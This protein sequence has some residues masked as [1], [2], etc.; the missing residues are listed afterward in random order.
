MPHHVSE[1]EYSAPPPV[2]DSPAV[3]RVLTPEPCRCRTRRR[4]RCRRTGISATTN[5]GIARL[6]ERADTFAWHRVSRGGLNPSIYSAD[7][8]WDMAACNLSGRLLGLRLYAPAD[9]RHAL[10]PTVGITDLVKRR[11]P[12]RANSPRRVPHGRQGC[13]AGGVSAIGGDLLRASPATARR[14]PQRPRLAAEFSRTARLLIPSRRAQSAP[15]SRRSGT[16]RS[17]A[18]PPRRLAWNGWRPM[19]VL[20]VGPRWVFVSALVRRL[21][22]GARC[23][24]RVGAGVLVL[25]G[26]RPCSQRVLHRRFVHR[27]GYCRGLDAVLTPTPFG[28][29]SDRQL[30]ARRPHA[31]ASMSVPHSSHNRPYALPS[32]DPATL[33]VR[34]R[35]SCNRLWA[36]LVARRVTAAPCGSPP[37]R[38]TAEVLLKYPSGT[39]LPPRS[40]PFPRRALV[41]GFSRPSQKGPDLELLDLSLALGPS[42]RNSMASALEGARTPGSA[43]SDPL[44]GRLTFAQHDH[45]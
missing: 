41:V 14:R 42:L 16:P 30:G 10:L 21:K 28:T 25:A 13:G 23:I 11:R 17:H 31:G 37:G 2:D 3:L 38:T 43:R 32:S 29:V 15:G 20:Y 19:L 44:G 7:S 24:Q 6:R 22:T 9:A 1:G 5:P 18:S 45:A 39:P 36:L 12:R 4:V 26:D 34:P 33:S 40:A 8:A 27:C 35:C